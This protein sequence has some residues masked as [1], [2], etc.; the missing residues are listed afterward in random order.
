M[1]IFDIIELKNHLS[2]IREYLMYLDIHPDELK[3]C[4]TL[5]CDHI[6]KSENILDKFD[7]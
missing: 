7:K 4:S 3:I 6:K 1:G 2:A 5:M